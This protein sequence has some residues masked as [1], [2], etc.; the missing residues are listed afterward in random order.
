MASTLSISSQTA[1][2]TRRFVEAS[3]R[4]M[5]RPVGL[6]DETTDCAIAAVTEAYEEKS[7]SR[8]AG[9]RKASGV[10]NASMI[11]CIGFGAD[12][13]EYLGGHYSLS[14]DRQTNAS[15][16]ILSAA[17]ILNKE[18][19]P[20]SVIESGLNFG[21]VVKSAIEVAWRNRR[22]GDNS[23]LDW[24]KTAASVLK[25]IKKVQEADNYAEL[26]DEEVLNRICDV[27]YDRLVANEVFGDDTDYF[28]GFVFDELEGCNQH[29]KD[30]VVLLVVATLNILS[31]ISY[32]EERLDAYLH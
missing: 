6:F 27:T 8:N 29:M 4:V 7:L 9:I 19:K 11:N 30:N 1:R 31:E 16:I 18:I 12:T 21:Y 23:S 13:G 24:D 26:S 22:L 17:S 10:Y 5:G 20:A 28:R 14:T 25:A 3:W 15:I 32:D 2:D